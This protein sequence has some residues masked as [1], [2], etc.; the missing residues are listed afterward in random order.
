MNPY[1]AGQRKDYGIKHVPHC[2]E[3]YFFW[4]LRDAVVQNHLICKASLNFKANGRESISALT[5]E[6][7]NK[8]EA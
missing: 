2:V 4:I 7:E 8:L 1:S 5:D 3:A 6:W